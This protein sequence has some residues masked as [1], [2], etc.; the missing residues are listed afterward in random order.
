MEKKK[1]INY[2]NEYL[3]LSDFSTDA[4]KNWLQVDTE[5]NKIQKIWYAVDANSYIF[6]KAIEEN[7]DLLITHHW[8]FWWEENTITNLYFER[9]KKLIK[10]DIWLYWVHLPLDA[11]PEIGNNIWLVNWLLNIFAINWENIHP[12]WEYDDINIGFWVNFEQKIPI[13]WLVSPFAE[14]IWIKPVLHNFGEKEFFQS[15]AIVSWGGGKLIPEIKNKKYDVFLTWE[16]VHHQIAMAK[17]LKQSIMLW[18]HRE[19]E[20][21]WVKLLAKHLEDIFSLKTVFLDQKY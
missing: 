16:A 13:S 17:E 3:K 14:K 5:K 18:W 6:D 2:L 9:I 11:H 8:L 12:V 7:I 1:L 10:N 19:T 15:I 20:K 4:S 21:I